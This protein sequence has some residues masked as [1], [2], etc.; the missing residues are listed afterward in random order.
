MSWKEVDSW[1]S[2]ANMY[3]TRQRYKEGLS[4]EGRDEVMQQ[5]IN[6]LIQEAFTSN[7]PKMVEMRL[8]MLR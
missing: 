6:K 3:Y 1:Q 7:D 5:L 2:D 4:Q 8:Q